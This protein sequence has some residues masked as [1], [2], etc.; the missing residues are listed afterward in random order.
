MFDR[1]LQ[2]LSI[3]GTTWIFALMLLV[4]ADIVS[5]FVFNAPIRGVAEIAGFSV[6]AIVFLQLPS[7]VR[8]RRLARADIV[9]Q[10]LH[11]R[12]P[13]AAAGIEAVFALL[14]AAVF[15]A[16]LWAAVMGITHAWQTGDRFGVQQVFTFPKW[17]IWLL[18]LVGSACVV[19]AFLVQAWLDLQGRGDHTAAPVQH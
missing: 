16:I 10:R 18:V 7:A 3:V 6:V 8:G 2:G 1:L 17:P 9:I 15:A 13:R 19:A 11:D 5:R 4:C 12:M 14:G